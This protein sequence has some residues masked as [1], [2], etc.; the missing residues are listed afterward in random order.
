MID[1]GKYGLM[2][3]QKIFELS[4]TVQFNAY[5]QIF[6]GKRES[7]NRIKKLYQ[8]LP[9][10][11]QDELFIS[12]NLINDL[13][14]YDDCNSLTHFNNVIIDDEVEMKN[15]WHVYQHFKN[16]NNTDTWFAIVPTAYLVMV[17]E[18]LI[19]QKKII[20]KSKLG[21]EMILTV[22]SN[23]E[24]GFDKFNF[25][26]ALRHAKTTDDIR[27]LS[28][29]IKQ[30]NFTVYRGATD[31]STPLEQ[32]ISWSLDYDVA[33]MFANRFNNHGKVFKATANINDVLAFIDSDEKEILIENQKLKNICVCE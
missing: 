9:L 23:S 12:T 15:I 30:E 10:S 28:K 33:K 16:T 2:S 32:T 19:D 26:K 3:A 27:K 13:V 5:H 11:E 7:F 20:P 8:K 1:F 18:N 25:V 31:K 14:L 4:S 29:I 24:Y 17:L 21:R 6:N 22:Y